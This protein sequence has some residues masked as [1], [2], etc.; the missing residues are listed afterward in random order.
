MKTL[1]QHLTALTW[2][3]LLALP[4]PASTLTQ[5]IDS[6]YGELDKAIAHA[7]QYVAQR[8]QRI[9]A[10]RQQ[11]SATTQPQRRYELLSSLYEEYAPLATD[12]AIHF[13]YQMADVARQQG[14][15]MRHDECLSHVAYWCSHAGMYHEAQTILNSIDT[16]RLD[17]K[18]RAAY[19]RAARHLAGELSYYTILP[20]LRAGYDADVERYAALMVAYTPREEDA[21]FEI[22]ELQAISQQKK[23][24]SMAINNT[25]M[26]HVEHGSHRY[27]LATFYRALEYNIR[28]QED[29]MVYWLLESTL[30]DVQGGVMDQGSMWELCNHLLQGGYTDRSFRYISYASHCAARFGSRQRNWRIAPLMTDIA[31]SYKREADQR[32]QLLMALAVLL[33]LL[34]IGIMVALFFVNS[35]RNKLAQARKR[36][37]EKN[38][39]LEET[40]KKLSQVNKQLHEANTEVSA[41]NQQLSKVNGELQESNRVKEEYVGRFMRLCTQNIDKMD[42]FRKQVNRMAK[43]RE[44]SSILELTRDHRNQEQMLETFYD[45]FDKAFLHLFPRFVE[46]FNGLL[47]PEE[48]VESPGKDKLNTTLRIFA[49]IRLGIDNSGKIAEFLHYSSNTIYNYRART[50]NAALNDRD[51]FEDHVKELPG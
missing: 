34:A 12:S 46:Q 3:L 44:L 38:Q 27:A 26:K 19:Y 5:R 43:N 11:V 45:D 28:G 23:K 22:R 20:Q 36:E 30:A 25:W 1:L 35:Q 4:S 21:S 31:D 8:E 48:R 14:W 18:S 49:L 24:E 9:T 6:L 10:L 51:H 40:N 2:M 7:G 15:H 50:K 47:R 37:M 17:S 42:A 29:E 13:L 16:L 33:A 32:A 39:L 41:I